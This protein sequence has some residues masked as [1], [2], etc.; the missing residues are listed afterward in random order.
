MSLWTPAQ[1][2]ERLQELEEDLG[3]RQ[4]L[5]EDAARSWYIAKRDREKAIATTFLTTDG[6]VAERKAHADKA[7]AAD[8]AR[9]EAEYEALKAVCRTIETRVGIG[10]SLLKAN[11]RTGS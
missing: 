5:L 11:G 2:M 7:H 6:T 9:E 1:I 3:K 8:G 10:Q 4:N